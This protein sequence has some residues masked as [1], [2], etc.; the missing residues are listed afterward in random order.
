MTHFTF[1]LVWEKK[2]AL[3]FLN[4]VF[5]LYWRKN[6]DNWD[7]FGSLTLNNGKL[8]WYFKSLWYDIH[9]HDAFM[10]VL[11]FFLYEFFALSVRLPA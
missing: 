4:Y 6:K 5:H 8:I 7:F 11:T 2:N 3:A 10:D 1:C 9:E